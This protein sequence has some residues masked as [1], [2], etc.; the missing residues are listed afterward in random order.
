MGNKVGKNEVLKDELEQFQISDHRS[1]DDIK[2]VLAQ[3][4]FEPV[5]KDWEPVI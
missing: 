2:A 3:Q 1:L 5:F 4:N